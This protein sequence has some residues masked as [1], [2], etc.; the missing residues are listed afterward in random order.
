MSLDDASE[1][2]DRLE[3]Q[4]QWLVA[5]LEGIR[6][7][8]PA[9]VGL[10]GTYRMIKRSSQRATGAAHGNDGDAGMRPGQMTLGQVMPQR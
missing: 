5:R 4:E 7:I 3:L 2:A 9:F 8:K 6:A 1:L 10:Y